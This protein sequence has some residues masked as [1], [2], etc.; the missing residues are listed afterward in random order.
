MSAP[1]YPQRRVLVRSL[2]AK[3]YQCPSHL[4]V[5]RERLKIREGRRGLGFGKSSGGYQ[6]EGRGLMRSADM[7]FTGLI[8][9]LLVIVGPICG[10]IALLK[11]RALGR[12]ITDLEHQPRSAPFA[13]RPEQPTPSPGPTPPVLEES[14][15]ALEKRSLLPG[16][17]PASPS[18]SRSALAGSTGS[19]S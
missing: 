12:K 5:R 3:V 6:S 18:R 10:I 14:L 8:I 19:A 15:A 1:W 2:L 11:V 17:S 4:R 13:V 7:I 9:L 16:R